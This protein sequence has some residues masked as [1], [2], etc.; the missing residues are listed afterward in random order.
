MCSCSW[1]ETG[2]NSRISGSP[3]NRPAREIHDKYITL[4]AEADAFGR[5]GKFNS[6]GHDR[7]LSVSYVV[8]SL[9]RQVHFRQVDELARPPVEDGFQHE[10]A[11]VVRLLERRRRRHHQFLASGDGIQERR[12]IVLE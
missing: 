10:H 4:D 6:H 1:L 9:T 7:L 11:E 12:A 2:V 8:A 3:L 5:F